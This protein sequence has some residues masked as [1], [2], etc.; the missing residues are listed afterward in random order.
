MASAAQAPRRSLPTKSKFSAGPAA[1]LGSPVRRRPCRPGQQWMEGERERER[2]LTAAGAQLRSSFSPAVCYYA[3][4]ICQLVDC[5]C[6][7]G[8]LSDKIPFCFISSLGLVSEY[9]ALELLLSIL[10]KVRH[11]IGCRLARNETNGKTSTNE[12]LGPKCYKSV[13][14]PLRRIC[15]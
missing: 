12:C 14:R 13:F 11:A 3:A 9:Q 2:Q 6:Q 5:C 15:L 8:F 10:N 7:D 4:R 1:A